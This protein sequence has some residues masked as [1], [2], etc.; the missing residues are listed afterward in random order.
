MRVIG[1]KGEGFMRRKD[2]NRPFGKLKAVEDFLPPPEDLFAEESL[3]KV[4]IAL[5][6]DT[7]VFFKK[8]ATNSNQKYQR[9]IREVLRKY[10]KKYRDKAF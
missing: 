6:E 5:D 9:M 4:T 7:I 2:K 8:V 3:K 1:E 10:A